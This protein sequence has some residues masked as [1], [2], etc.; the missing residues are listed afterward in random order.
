MQGMM[1]IFLSVLAGVSFLLFLLIARAHITSEKYASL[2][3]QNEEKYRR[4]IENIRNDHVIYSFT[5]EGKFIYLSP[6]IEKILGYS[7]DEIME[8]GWNGFNRFHDM[9]QV[10]QEQLKLKK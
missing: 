10:F 4:L 7:K 1:P 8:E 9:Q 3:A 2:V 6:S 5:A